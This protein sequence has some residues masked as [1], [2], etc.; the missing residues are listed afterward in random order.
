MGLPAHPRTSQLGL[1]TGLPQ[2]SSRPD[3]S[4]HPLALI[5]VRS[6]SLLLAQAEQPLHHSRELHRQQQVKQRQRQEEAEDLSALAQ[7]QQHWNGRLFCSQQQ[8]TLGTCITDS[9]C[10][11]PIIEMLIHH[12]WTHQDPQ[13]LARPNSTQDPH[14]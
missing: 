5:D 10:R 6:R 8:P 12:S 3:T 11:K 14:V 13:P 4:S 2:H 9:V 7:R 1:V